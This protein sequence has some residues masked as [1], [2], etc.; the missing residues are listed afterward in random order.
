[1]KCLSATFSVT[2]AA[3]PN[4]FKTLLIY[5][6]NWFINKKLVMMTMMNSDGDY[7][8]YHENYK[9][10]GIFDDVMMM[11]MMIIIM[12]MMMCSND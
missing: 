2:S 4:F 11:M 9:I 7:Y 1:M 12:M 6:L 3:P 8:D 10:D 5:K